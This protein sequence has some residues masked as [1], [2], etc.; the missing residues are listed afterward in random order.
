MQIVLSKRMQAVAAMVTPGRQRVCDV[1]CD[2]GYVSIYLVQ[3]GIS[4]KALA[5]D[6]RKGPLSQAQIHIRE[7]GLEAY[8]ET[9]LSDGLSMIEPGECDAMICAGMG[10]KLMAQILSNGLE[11]AKQMK[12]LVLQPQSDLKFFRGWLYDH[13]FVIVAENMICEEGKY[14]PM[15]KVQPG[16]PPEEQGQCLSQKYGSCLLKD[17]NEALLQY[18]IWQR[19]L[20]QEI[21]RQV[22]EKTVGTPG[23]QARRELRLQQIR[24]ELED[25]TA[26]L[27]KM[28]YHNNL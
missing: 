19:K 14:Y 10:G 13:C 28:G 20:Q 6:V 24:Q 16:I 7:A 23:A 12:E 26:A 15:M 25:S 4:R 2:H 17:K 22:S 8:I 18:L 3:Q 5:T 21:Q 11:T 27:K 9:R 1:G